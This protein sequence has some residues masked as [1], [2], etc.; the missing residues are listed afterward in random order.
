MAAT[1][2]IPI[3]FAMGSDP[4]KQGLVVSLGRPGGNA[5]GVSFFTT[6]LAAKRLELLRELVPQVALIGILANPSLLEGQD[7]VAEIQAAARGIGQA[8]LVLN[9]GNEGEIN[10]AFAGATERRVGAM[11]VDGDAVFR[12]LRGQIA[13]LA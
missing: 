5:T 11:L 12:N 2:T 8:I 4:V 3:V 7:N 9:A 13:G 6:A 10:T 1:S